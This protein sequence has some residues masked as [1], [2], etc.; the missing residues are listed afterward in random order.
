[1][2][3][4]VNRMLADILGGT[5]V[6]LMETQGEHF[7]PLLLAGVHK[8]TWASPSPGLQALPQARVAGHWLLSFSH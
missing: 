3:G 4:M 6:G 5:S 1:M 7:F 8:V 2:T